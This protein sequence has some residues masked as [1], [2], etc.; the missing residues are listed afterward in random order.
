MVICDGFNAPTNTSTPLAPFPR[1]NSLQHTSNGMKPTYDLTETPVLL[2]GT[3][4]GK[5][6]TNG[7]SAPPPPVEARKP[8]AKLQQIN[9]NNNNNKNKHNNS[10]N[11]DNLRSIDSDECQQ[12]SPTESNSASNLRAQF[13]KNGSNGACKLPVP[14]SANSTPV[15]NQSTITSS[16]PLTDKNLMLNIINRSSQQQDPKSQS[17]F[18]PTNGNSKNNISSNNNNNASIV[19]T[20]VSSIQSES[21]RSFRDKKQFFETCKDSATNLMK[22]RKSLKNSF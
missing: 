21:V 10:C 22:R 4:S 1:L 13:F 7:H 6:V 8:S 3:L 20:P 14:V 11:Y 16:L 17:M 5:A 9:N 15:S 19:K 18:T 12:S 2:N